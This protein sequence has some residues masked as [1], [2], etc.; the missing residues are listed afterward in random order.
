MYV[1]RAYNS[2]LAK[3]M[4]ELAFKR[5]PGFYFCNKDSNNRILY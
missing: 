1:N 2:L 4:L 5:K 3:I